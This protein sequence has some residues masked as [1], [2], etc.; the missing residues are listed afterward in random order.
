M[1]VRASPNAAPHACILHAA[2]LQLPLPPLAL[3]A[4][5]AYTVCMSTTKSLYALVP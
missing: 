2:K 3:R 1:Y 4:P 5:T